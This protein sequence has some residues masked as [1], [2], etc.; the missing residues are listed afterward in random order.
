L[1]IVLSVLLR[2]TDSDYLP[3]VSLNSSCSFFQSQSDIIYYL[4]FVY[5]AE[6]F[7]YFMEVL[8]SAVGWFKTM[9]DSREKILLGFIGTN[10]CYLIYTWSIL[11][12]IKPLLL[13]IQQSEYYQS[14]FVSTFWHTWSVHPKEAEAEYRKLKMSNTG[15]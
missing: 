13:W 12:L 2:C 8:C 4:Y 3:L 5:N 9:T 1:A 7:N 6:H 15:P 10:M 11:D 14:Y